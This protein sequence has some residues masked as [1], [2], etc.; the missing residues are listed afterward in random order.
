MTRLFPFRQALDEVPSDYYGIVVIGPD[1]LQ[2]TFWNRIYKWNNL[3]EQR[4]QVATTSTKTLLC[5]Y[6]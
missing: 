6:S 5:N 3:Y 2:S 1:I 4:T